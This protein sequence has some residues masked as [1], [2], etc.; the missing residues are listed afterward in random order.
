MKQEIQIL[1][2]GNVQLTQILPY[3]CNNL[4]LQLFQIA[5]LLNYG[6]QLFFLET[7]PQ[8]ACTLASVTNL[9]SCIAAYSQPLRGGV[10]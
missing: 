7:R 6:V 1:T 3:L 5:H 4:L 8:I 2:R 9:S 10:S